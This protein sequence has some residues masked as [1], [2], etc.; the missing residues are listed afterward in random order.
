LLATCAPIALFTDADLS[1]PLEEI[2]RLLRD[3]VRGDLDVA[4]GSRALDRRLI[5]V[6]QPRRR[7]FAGRAFNVVLRLATKLPFW[8]TQCGFKAF[9]MSVCRPLLEVGTIDGFGFDIELLYEAR[10]AGLRMREIPVRWDHHDGSKV[11]CLRDGVRML[12]DIVTVRMR[13][14]TGFYDAGVSLAGA[15]ARLNG[16]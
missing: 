12:R 16:A 15:A 5:G 10:R 9:R 2:P 1:T 7:E 4:L 11:N 3:L 14:A 6:R 13:G 8:D